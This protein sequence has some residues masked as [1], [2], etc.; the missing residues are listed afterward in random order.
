MAGLLQQQMQP[1]AEQPMPPAAEQPAPGGRPSPEAQQAGSDDNVNMDPERGQEQRAA[2]IAAMLTPLYDEMMPQATDI[3]RQSAESP[4]EGIARILSQV[5]ITAWQALADQGKTI[6][7][8]VMF[9]SAMVA[10]QAIGDM[11]IRLGVLPQEGHGD[12]IEAGFMIAMGQFGKAT[13]QDMPPEQ[14]ARY[15]DLIESMREAKGMAQGSGRDMQDD[16]QAMPR[17][18]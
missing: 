17:G 2:V 14:R 11:A 3:L 7:P 18:Q 6:P 16:A 8:G 1:S 12:L 15:R 10:A 9:Q 4:S 5:M 13:S